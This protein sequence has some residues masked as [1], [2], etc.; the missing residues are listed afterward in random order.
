MGAT[1]RRCR[2]WQPSDE[3]P[4]DEATEGQC[5]RYPMQPMALVSHGTADYPFRAVHGGLNWLLWP[6]TDDDEW[7]GE[8]QEHR[9]YEVG[10]SVEICGDGDGAD[11]V[12]GTIGCVYKSG[13]CRVDLP[14]G[15]FRNLPTECLKVIQ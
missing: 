3:T 14:D 2:F 15:G 8:W 6:S 11:G 7:C 13:R 1:C 4:R 10:V 5:H 12:H 9:L